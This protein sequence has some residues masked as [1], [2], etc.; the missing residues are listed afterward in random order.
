MKVLHINSNYL[1]SRLHENLMGKLEEKELENT[2]FMPMKSE[3]NEEIKF[4]SQFNVHNPVAFNHKD[5]YFFIWK[6]KKIL[7]KLLS[8]IDPKSYN[9]SH[10]HTLFTD[11]NVA[12]K[13]KKEYNIPYVVTVRGYT[14]INSFFKRRINLRNRGRRILE[15]AS[16]IIFLSETQRLELLERY[17][18]DD[19]LKEH[20]LKNSSVI[21]N[22]IDSFWFENEG[23]AKKLNKQDK[24]KLISVGEVFRLKNQLTTIKVA[25]Y[26]K[27]E[28]NMDVSVTLVGK[29]RDKE[30]AKELKKEHSVPIEIHEFVPKEK[31]IEFYRENDIFILP[32][33]HETFGLVYP[34]AMSQGLPIIYTKNQGFYRQFEEG[35]AGYGVVATDVKDISQKVLNILKNYVAIS[36]NTL[37]AYKKF[38]W[39]NLSKEISTVYYNI[40]N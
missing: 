23:P 24:L 13:L 17:I 33:I 34:E 30:Y 18:K 32:S 36:E 11:G 10:A 37:E 22:G 3:K 19:S 9:L 25:E 29:T 27:E 16:H 20:I 21:P 2:I 28:Y 5:R 40:L 1:T 26:L 35:Y 8:V 31:L 38:D 15:N 7:D 4:E 6:Q 14:D 12:Y 39:N